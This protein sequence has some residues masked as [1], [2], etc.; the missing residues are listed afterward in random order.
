MNIT[1]IIMIQA[2]EIYSS[3]H[4]YRYDQNHEY[5]LLFKT[6]ITEI[7]INVSIKKLLLLLSILRSLI[8][9]NYHLILIIRPV[10]RNY[11]P[12]FVINTHTFFQ[13]LVSFF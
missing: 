7:L 12:E 10:S 3:L 9:K 11:V 1:Y 6:V 2:I 5:L 4:R 8:A 13:S